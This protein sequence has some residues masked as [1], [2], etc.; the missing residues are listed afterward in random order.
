MLWRFPN[1]GWVKYKTDGVSRGNPGVS[2][3]AFCL[4]DTQGDL[5]YDQGAKMEDTS[6]MEA[7]TMAILQAVRHYSTSIYDK[8]VFQTDS[9]FVQKTVTREWACPW[10]LTGYLEQIWSLTSHKQIKIQ[11]IIREGNQFPD[12][13][14]NQAIDKGEFF[15]TSFQQLESKGKRIL[16]SDKMQ[17]PYIR[18]SPLR[19]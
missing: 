9:L 17:C 6:N 19:G 12:H 7:E 10:N 11:H 8:T 15:F 18:V 2:S 1:E 13:L 5:I 14:A 4:R 3:Y 16:S